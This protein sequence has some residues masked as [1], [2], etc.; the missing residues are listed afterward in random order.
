[1]A[2]DKFDRGSAL[3]VFKSDRHEDFMALVL[4]LVIA[5]LV[6]LFV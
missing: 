4:A 5:L 6:Y 2:E 3:T 1:M